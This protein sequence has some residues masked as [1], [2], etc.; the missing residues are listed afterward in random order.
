M[1][2]TW[3]SLWHHPVLLRWNGMPL[4]RQASQYSWCT[5]N[6][7]AGALWIPLPRQPRM[8]RWCRGRS[9]SL[10]L[11]SPGSGTR[12]RRS[13]RCQCSRNSH[14]RRCPARQCSLSLSRTRNT[15]RCCSWSLRSP[16]SCQRRCRSCRSSLS[17]SRTR[18]S[19]R[20]WWSLSLRS[21]SGQR[22]LLWLT[23]CSCR[24]PGCLRR[25]TRCS[26]PS[27]GRGRSSGTSCC[28]PGLCS[29]SRH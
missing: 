16:W 17:L 20:S 7:S 28:S 1:G 14:Q 12:Q 22:S 29:L 27:S 23:A 19:A 4:T 24:C 3:T 21:S 11:T 9:C 13:S 26:F 8:G 18:M 5:R 2:S 6:A 15:L 25:R 10:L